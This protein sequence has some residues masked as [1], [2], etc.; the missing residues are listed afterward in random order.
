VE[1]VGF[2]LKET[3]KILGV[4]LASLLAVKAAEGLGLASHNGLAGRL[5]QARVWI[6]LVIVV[7]AGLGAR[8]VGYDVAAEAYYWA[9]LH[10]VQHSRFLK[11]YS[12]TDQ[13]VMLRPA[14]PRYWAGLEVAKMNLHQFAS[15]ADDLPAMRQVTGG[16][17]DETDAY[18]FA[19]ALFLLGRYDEAENITE[20]LITQNRFF[21][22]PHILRGQILTS[23]QKYM[24]AEQAFLVALQVLPTDQSAVEGLAHACFLEGNRAQALNVLGEASRLPFSTEARTRFQ[25]LKDL[26]AQ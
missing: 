17:L 20:R 19:V 13:A 1:L 22:P 2:F 21:V 26:Y 10:D 8:N 4:I 15:I 7:L 11:A 14:V 9:G 12:N 6:Y 25:A 3:L 5:A 18:R 24:E 16:E 23:Q